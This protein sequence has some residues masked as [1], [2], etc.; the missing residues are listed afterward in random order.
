MSETSDAMRIIIAAQ[1]LPDGRDM[2]HRQIRWIARKKVRIYANEYNI[3]DF[4]DTALVTDR[5][6]TKRT[7]IIT[8]AQARVADANAATDMAELLVVF[9]S[10]APEIE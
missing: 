10:I 4:Q 6:R 9:D 8:E 3:I 5:H 1:T 2:V 7:D